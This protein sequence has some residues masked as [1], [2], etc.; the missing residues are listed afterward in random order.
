MQ[1]I[2]GVGVDLSR[3]ERFR[4]AR[5]HERLASYYL[6]PEEWQRLAKK[7]DVAQQLAARFAAKEAVIKAVP[8]RVRS[9][10]FEIVS[11]G[12]KPA[13]R[14]LV[15]SPYRILL[16]ISHETDH[17]CAVAICLPA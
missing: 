16:S 9:I 13:V 8:E 10:D 2:L 15:P 7:P 1:P 11:E 6:S 4:R 5:H 17:A 14:W 3:I 12:E